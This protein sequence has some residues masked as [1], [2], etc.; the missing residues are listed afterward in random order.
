MPAPASLHGGRVAAAAD[1]VIKVSRCAA[2][3]FAPRVRGSRGRLRMGKHLDT[4]FADLSSA[5]PSRSSSSIEYC[6]LRLLPRIGATCSNIVIHATLMWKTSRFTGV[7]DMNTHL[8]IARHLPIYG[9]YY[10]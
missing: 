3:A 6:A 5:A 2:P 8:M 10:T 7:T 4:I 1:I 9:Q